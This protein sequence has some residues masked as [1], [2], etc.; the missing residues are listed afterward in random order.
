MRSKRQNQYGSVFTEIEINVAM[1]VIHDTI[2]NGEWPRDEEDDL[3][4]FIFIHLWEKRDKYITKLRYANYV[5]RIVK[6]K[7]LNLNEKR[8]AKKRKPKSKLLSLDNPITTD[9]SGDE[10]T[11]YHTTCDDSTIQPDDP[12]LEIYNEI[13]SLIKKQQPNL[14]DVCEQLLNGV[15]ITEMAKIIGKKRTT[16]SDKVQKLKRMIKDAGF[17]AYIK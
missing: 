8:N 17:D 2:N 6:N 5:R 16:V 7:I 1:K 13:W 3:K 4:Q 15:S 11:L 12:S 9:E 14:Q 10:T